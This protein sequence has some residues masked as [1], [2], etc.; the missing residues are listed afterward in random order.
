MRYIAFSQ[1]LAGFLMQSGFVL[2]GVSKDKKSSRNVFL[3][4]K[5]EALEEAV[6]EYRKRN[7]K[8]SSIE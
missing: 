3:F 4:N 1:R 6:E 7:G 2:M 5:S 8:E